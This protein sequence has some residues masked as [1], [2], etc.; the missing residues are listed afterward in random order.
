MVYTDIHWDIQWYTLW[1]HWYTIPYMSQII[2]IV[3]DF[4]FINFMCCTFKAL[5]ISPE[6][7]QQNTDAIKTNVL[8]ARP[9]QCNASWFGIYDILTWCII[10]KLFFCI[11]YLWSLKSNALESKWGT[12]TDLEYLGESCGAFWKVFTVLAWVSC[13]GGPILAWECPIVLTPIT[14]ALIL[15]SHL[16]CG[17]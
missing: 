17:C 15:C 13:G 4:Q 3:K 11:L 7:T 9:N 14:S 1:Y 2:L 12:S 16:N 10:Q 5:Y 6:S 8:N